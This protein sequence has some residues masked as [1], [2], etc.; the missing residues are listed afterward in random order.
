MQNKYLK[1]QRI[2]H[3]SIRHEPG[4]AF[5]LHTCASQVDSLSTVLSTTL[6]EKTKP[7]IKNF[8]LVN[9]KYHLIEDCAQRNVLSGKSGNGIFLTGPLRGKHGNIQIRKH[10]LEKWKRTN[11]VVPINSNASLRQLIDMFFLQVMRRWLANNVSVY[12]TSILLQKGSLLSR[13]LPSLL[14]VF[15]DLNN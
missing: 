3:I 1:V 10:Q 8:S 6:S 9:S 4:P 12:C 7:P 13:V 11:Q 14:R 15:R 2:A 5:C